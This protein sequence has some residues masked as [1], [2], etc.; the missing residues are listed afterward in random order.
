M[1]IHKQ[2]TEYHDLKHDLFARIS[3][4]N[5]S[6]GIILIIGVVYLVFLTISLFI[7]AIREPFAEIMG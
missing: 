2:Y 4:I 5:K 3:R 1:T 6:A 7:E